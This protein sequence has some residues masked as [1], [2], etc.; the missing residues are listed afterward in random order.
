MVIWNDS[1]GLTFG[2]ERLE[3]P[4]KKKKELNIRT[5]V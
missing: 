3:L 4:E 1:K 5:P 2:P